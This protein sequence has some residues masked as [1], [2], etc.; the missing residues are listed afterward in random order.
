MDRPAP[1][2]AGADGSKQDAVHAAGR[3]QRYAMAGRQVS[4]APERRLIPAL[5]TCAE[6]YGNRGA[7]AA[8][9]TPGLRLM[10]HQPAHAG[11]TGASATVF[12]AGVARGLHPETR[13]SKPSAGSVA[14]PARGAERGP[15]TADVPWLSPPHNENRRIM[16]LMF[17]ALQHRPNLATDVKRALSVIG[18]L[19]LQTEADVLRVDELYKRSRT[20]PLSDAQWR[21]LSSLSARCVDNM[22]VNQVKLRVLFVSLVKC[23]SL[24]A[25]DAGLLDSIQKRVTDALAYLQSDDLPWFDTARLVN[26][27]LPIGA[28]KRVEV[29]SRVVPGSALGA[30]F[31]NGYPEVGSA[32][33][34]LE[35]RLTHVPDLSQTS[36]INKTGQQLFSGLRH[37]MVGAREL[38]GTRLRQLSDEDLRSLLERILA[39][40][41]RALEV[42]SDVVE[43]AACEFSSVRKS[44][45]GATAVGHMLAKS[46]RRIVARETAVAA[47]VADPD[48]FGLALARRKV[49]LDLFCVALMYPWEVK[50]WN[51]Q[52]ESLQ[53]LQQFWPCELNVR[54]ENGEPRKVLANLSIRGFVLSLHARGFDREA[55]EWS[56]AATQGR[57]LLGPL[58]EPILGGDVKARVDQ[59]AAGIAEMVQNCDSL[60]RECLQ[61]VQER[62][63]DCPDAQILSDRWVTLVAEKELLQRS[64]RA[65]EEAGQQLK[66]VWMQRGNWPAGMDGSRHVAARL[67]L[68]GH[69]MGETPVFI[70]LSGRDFV[71]HL[72][73][74]V[75]FLA[76]VA[77]NQGGQVPPIGLDMDVWGTARSFFLNQ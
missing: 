47:L 16:I 60:R 30:H 64:V 75:K 61:T 69:L 22:P 31:A 44:A 74:E 46:V 41:Q 37:G 12:H 59:M 76:T 72:D 67:G 73:S 58:N 21:E 49:D 68:V 19:A 18:E 7:E 27:T 6:T 62:G 29:E 20:E 13:V 39:T 66:D 51:D 11:V 55:V 43:S 28:G 17:E 25:S 1:V 14:S 42:G 34:S 8:S 32:H 63:E 26:V 4:E 54:G 2:P 38:N 36:L 40:P 33:R 71:H 52:L 50:D 77:D 35:K 9:E 70:S 57:K 65:L 3:L 15:D 53:R 23:D 5:S 10:V 45:A 24:I 48:K 56:C